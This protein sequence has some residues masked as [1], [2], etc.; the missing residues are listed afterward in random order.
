VGG[1]GQGADQV[2]DKPITPRPVAMSRA[3]RLKRVFGIEI[4]TCA[5]CGGRL[6]VI[7]SSE[8]PE[9]T[10]KIPAQREKAAPD[11]DQPELPL[12]ARAPPAQVRLI[13]HRSGHCPGRLL[14]QHTQR[15]GLARARSVRTGRRRL[16]MAV[17]SPGIDRADRGAGRPASRGQVAQRGRAVVPAAER[18]AGL[19]KPGGLNFLSALLSAWSRRT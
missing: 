4:N 18:P 11:H 6:E 17:P 10:A 9:V 8:A 1:K 7:A 16:K 12:G 2:T 3:Q 19:S 5:R 15:V 13:W 14:R